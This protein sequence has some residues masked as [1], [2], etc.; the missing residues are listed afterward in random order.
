M[1]NSKKLYEIEV[2]VRYAVII[3]AT[4]AKQALAHVETWGH[5]WDANADLL[6]VHGLEITD[7]RSGSTEEA[8]ETAHDAIKE[9]VDA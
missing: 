2:L 5:A 8:H 7:V 6:E 4:S 3:Q 9:V 1:A